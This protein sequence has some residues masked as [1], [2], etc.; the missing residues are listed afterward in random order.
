MISSPPLVGSK[1]VL[2]VNSQQSHFILCRWWL[3]PPPFL[4]PF[5]TMLSSPKSPPPPRLLFP[6]HISDFM[7][8]LQLLLYLS[9]FVTLMH[10]LR[11]K[12][13]SRRDE[14]FNIITA[15]NARN[16]SK[17]V[18][19]WGWGRERKE[20]S[21]ANPS[22]WKIC[23]PTNGTSDWCGVM[24]LTGLTTSYQNPCAKCESDLGSERSQWRKTW[25]VL[26]RPVL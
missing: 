23:L 3:N 14:L 12:R 4:S 16:E 17:R 1:L 7:M 5:E 24:K 19:G 25:E 9:Y 22:F 10:C 18:A 13:S 6:F 15:R 2:A 11:N 26:A 8:Y 21:Q 20:G